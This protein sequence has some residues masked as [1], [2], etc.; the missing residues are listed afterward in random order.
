[1]RNLILISVCALGSMVSFAGNGNKDKEVKLEKTTTQNV[2][3]L[4][5]ENSQEFFNHT[6]NYAIV[7]HVYSCPAEGGVNTIDYFET[8]SGANGTGCVD[9]A[10]LASM[11]ALYEGIADLMY[12]DACDIDVFAVKLYDCVDED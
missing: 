1:M 3:N 2:E 4:C 5:A 11:I 10:Q 12:P 6:A 9:D 8:L 7:A